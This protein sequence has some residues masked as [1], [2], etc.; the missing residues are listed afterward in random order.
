MRTDTLLR[1]VCGPADGRS[2]RKRKEQRN[3]M[4]I[5]HHST[6]IIG[7]NSGRSSVA[8]VAY[9]CGLELTD[10]R[11]GKVHNYT[12]KDVDSY[13]TLAPV[14][15]PSWV[16][17][18]EK[19]WNAVEQCEKRKDAQ[20][21]R[22]INIALPRELDKEQMKKLAL[23]YVQDQFVNKGMIAVVAFHDL[24]S[25]NPHFHTMLTLREI[26]EDGFGKK[27]R[28]WNQK[29]LVTIYRKN[30]AEAVNE[31]LEMLGFTDRIDY[32][33]FIEQGIF[34]KAPTQHQGQKAT[35]MES[36]GLEPDRK[37]IVKTP[38]TK[39]VVKAIENLKLEI[40]IQL[41]EI[42]RDEAK[43]D[44][45]VI[46]K[47]V[48]D[49]S[50]AIM[51]LKEDER[52]EYDKLA[53]LQS[54]MKSKDDEL[55]TIYDKV[56]TS[57]KIFN[58]WREEHKILS[59]MFTPERVKKAEKMFAK[60]SDVLVKEQKRIDGLSNDINLTREKIEAMSSD[61]KKL[62]QEYVIKFDEMKKITAMLDE[63][64]NSYFEPEKKSGLDNAIVI[65]KQ[66][67]ET[68]RGI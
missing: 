61:R 9:R 31:K 54:R 38:Q 11:T 29:E 20:L 14:G 64:N 40:K 53:E 42:D 49:F 27:N 22:E 36:R 21:C 15:S 68:G 65:K 37:K 51:K 32:R 33:S 57:S 60:Y 19:L 1:N 46:E 52:S 34:D 7:R 58:G 48:H 8:S 25:G 45:M 35:A 2:K 56:I 67:R 5:F 24:D 41:D 4:A 30:W 6:Q 50:K 62:S 12:K 17:N 59:K 39:E 3:L 18:P 43:N 13:Y 16:D 66:G 28:D 44:L 26:T 47:S 23:D 10:E 55:K 63:R